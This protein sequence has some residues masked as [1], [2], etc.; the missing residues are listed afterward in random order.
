MRRTKTRRVGTIGSFRHLTLDIHPDG[1]YGAHS[2]GALAGAREKTM[3]ASKGFDQSVVDH[4]AT[5]MFTDEHHAAVKGHID[6]TRIKV[7]ANKDQYEGLS[8]HRITDMMAS[9]KKVRDARFRPKYHDGGVGYY[10]AFRK[11]EE[12][13][14]ACVNKVNAGADVLIIP[15]PN[16]RAKSSHAGEPTQIQENRSVMIQRGD[17]SKIVVMFCGVPDITKYGVMDPTSIKDNKGDWVE[18]VFPPKYKHL[19]SLDTH[20]H[21]CFWR[22]S[23]DYQFFINIYLTNSITAVG[24]W[25][26]RK[27][28]SWHRKTFLKVIAQKREYTRWEGFVSDLLRT[29]WFIR[30]G[31]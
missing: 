10:K 13:V 8:I 19:N 26:L 15:L 4:M 27:C 3:K 20:I 22:T 11:F 28:A 30:F 1:H 21:S 24:E 17:G 29:P 12:Y 18:M 9:M 23:Y 16:F 2:L 14:K 7:N 6:R 31:R 25:I 5:G